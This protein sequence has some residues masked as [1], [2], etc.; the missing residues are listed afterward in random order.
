MKERG[1]EEKKELCPFSENSHNLAQYVC[2][3]GHLF[4]FQFEFVATLPPRFSFLPL[5]FY[6]QIEIYKISIYYIYYI[7]LFMIMI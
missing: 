7:G 2:D 5:S 1:Q 4:L 3:S 6:H